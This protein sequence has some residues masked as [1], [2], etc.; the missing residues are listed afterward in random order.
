MSAVSVRALARGSAY[1][2]AAQVW[3]MASRLVLTPIV[4]ARLGLEGYGAWTLV[5][6]LCS[7]A[8][9]LDVGA[10]WAYAKLTAELDERGNYSVLSDVLSSGLVLVGSAAA[11]GLTAVWL[12]HAWI[13]PILGV[14]QHLLHET[15]RTL[16]VLSLAVAFEAWAGCALDVLAGLQR[17]DL[18]YRF[19]IFG[20]VV[21][22]ATALPL[23]LAGVGMMALPFGVLAG[24]AVSIGAAWLQCRRLRP[25]LHLSPLRASWVG[26]RHVVRLGI[27]FQS[28]VL[29]GTTV[30]QGIRL[31]ISSLYGTAALGI[32]NLAD[33][34]LFV[35]HT[36]GLAIVSPLMPAFA[37][38]GSADDTRRWRR[39]F[40]RAS[41]VLGVAAAV[42][43]LFAAV[44]AGPILFAWTGRRFPD[45]AWTVRVLAP[46]EFATLLA[47]VA[48]ARLRAA[49]TV[50]LELT[51]GLLGSALALVGL[52]AAYPLAGYAGSVVAVACGRS[53][54]AVW[55]F[56][57]FAASRNLDR[58]D[59]VR[60][61]VLAPV[62][63][64][65][66][67]CLLLG[68]AT[69]ALPIL[70][71]DDAGRWAVLGVL[72]LLAAAYALACAP[73][74]WF[75]GLS[76]SERARVV[77]LI[78]RTRRVGFRD[79]TASARAGHSS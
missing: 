63:L 3:Q 12:A 30:R 65:G 28:L 8:I 79:L 38:L 39:L 4:I 60:T 40:L 20:S 67:V 17:M 68:S 32:F 33:R 58:W 27:R 64:F 72:A 21:E 70:N 6:S 10:G 13:L 14:P 48:G 61:T 19:I 56:A 50:R 36:P 69:F 76:A 18:K 16:L 42:P 51:S 74:A 57:R 52:A 9:A 46:V 34:L 15:E 44:F 78:R 77:R 29:V 1:V 26:M 24:D 59:Y 62:L 41:K 53:I 22:F 54:G 73:V 47:G 31:L 2:N 7:Y 23:L 11:L 45:A 71:S 5:F 37:R 75:L 49:G 25:A 55:F 35:A 66:P 43:L